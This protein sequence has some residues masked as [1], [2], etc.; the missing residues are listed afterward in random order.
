M[1]PTPLAANVPVIFCVLAKLSGAS[2]QRD[3]QAGQL[4]CRG[5]KHIVYFGACKLK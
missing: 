3:D 5:R 4:Q 1:L 2:G